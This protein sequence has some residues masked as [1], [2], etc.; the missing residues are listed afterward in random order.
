[1]Y[2]EL[3]E[4]LREEARQQRTT[5]YEDIAPMLGLKIVDPAD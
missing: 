2:D 3:Y 1:M 5:H 4:K